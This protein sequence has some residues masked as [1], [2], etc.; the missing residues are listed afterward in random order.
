MPRGGWK[1]GLA[2]AA[3]LGSAPAWSE[4]I[5]A[6][7]SDF[8]G[9]GLLEMRNARFREDGTLEVGGA[10]RHQRRFWFV[11]FQALPFLETTFRLTE[12]LDGT[13]GQGMTTDRAFDL[14]LRLVEETETRPAIAIGLQDFIG[15]G[16]Y[17]GEYIVASKR[18]HG[19]DLTAGLGWGRLGTG[20]EW[21]SPLALGDS[22]F[23][24]R[25]RDVGRGGSLQTGLFR[26]ED[27][28]PFFGVE[29][30]IPAIPTPWGDVE[31]FRAKVEWS[32]DALRDER[33]GYPARRANLRGEANSRVNLGL[34][35]ASEHIEA[36]IAWLHGTDF[37]FKLSFRLN[38][39]EPPAAPLPPAPPM[40]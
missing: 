32:A 26:G 22:R 24:D 17:A 5:P 7:G 33:G 3:L 8:G 10:L 28:S 36:G 30:S 35:W 19:F 23:R 15:T 13:T 11:N 40:P 6:S 1:L 9:A 29:Y 4:E 21:T 27:V 14:K 34:H 12:R 39:A 16:L 38:P 25:P 37:L 20:G 2:M 31:G 18:W